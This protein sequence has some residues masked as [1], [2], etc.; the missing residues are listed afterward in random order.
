MVAIAR[1]P[2]HGL[3]GTTARLDVPLGVAKER[4]RC[5]GN[6]VLP[7]QAA[8]AIRILAD[9]IGGLT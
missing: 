2:E 5:L 4:L 8:Y 6:G 3:H 1:C 7:A 9:R